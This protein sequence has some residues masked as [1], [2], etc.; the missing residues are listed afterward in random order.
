[1]KKATSLLTNTANASLLHG[2]FTKKIN[3][4]TRK[5][6]YQEWLIK[7]NRT[8]ERS[9]DDFVE[10][11]KAKYGLPLPIW[12]AIELWD[13]GLLSTFYKGMSVKDK[14][15]IAKRY[16]ISDW[17]IMESWLRT[18][19]YVRNVV[20]HHNRLWN[21]NLVDQPKLPK[22]GEMPE[23]DSFLNNVDIT[24]RIYIVLCILAHFIGC[25]CP[26]SSWRARLAGLIKLFPLSAHVN[27]EDMGF[28]TDW[29][30]HIFWND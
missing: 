17:Q 30:K 10:H 23:F 13:F 2:N 20:A 12:V 25:I 4:R 15:V 14:T 29:D 19:N 27:I 8:I 7:H 1:M 3:N 5:T 16:G 6:R 11:Y 18:L 28:P 26:R 22:K 24:S 9:K 21:R